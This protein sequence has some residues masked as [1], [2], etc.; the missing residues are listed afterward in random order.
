MI[1]D[2][3]KASNQTRTARLAGLH[4]RL[5]RNTRKRAGEHVCCVYARAYLCVCVCVCVRVLHVCDICST[6]CVEIR[7][8]EQVK[9]VC[10]VCMRVC[11]CVCARVLPVCV[12]ARPVAEKYAKVSS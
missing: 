3:R 9:N 7:E 6:G 4:V 5:R 12:F 10:A 1:I 2:R 11:M 8:S